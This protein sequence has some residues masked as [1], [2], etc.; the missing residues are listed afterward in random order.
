MLSFQDLGFF[1]LNNAKAEAQRSYAHAALTGLSLCLVILR[2]MRITPLGVCLMVNVNEK[3]L[4]LK[5]RHH[6]FYLYCY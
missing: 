5:R 4:I 1:A 6:V 3:P 2:K